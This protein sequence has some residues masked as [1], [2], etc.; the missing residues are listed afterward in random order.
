VLFGKVLIGV[1]H[2]NSLGFDWGIVWAGASPIRKYIDIN[3]HP[4]ILMPYLFL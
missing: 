3:R 4:W 1:A 2:S